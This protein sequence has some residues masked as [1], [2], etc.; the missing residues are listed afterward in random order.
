MGCSPSL[1]QALLIE[2]AFHLG[3][4]QPIGNA[5]CGQYIQGYFLL[6]LVLHDSVNIFLSLFP[7]PSPSFCKRDWFVGAFCI[8]HRA[9]Q[10]NMALMA[11]LEARSDEM[12]KLHA[13]K[14][15]QWTTELFYSR[16]PNYNFTW[17]NACSLI[18]IH[19]I[20]ARKR[21]AVGFVGPSGATSIWSPEN[22]ILR[23]RSTL[24]WFLDPW[25]EI[26]V[27]NLP[28]I[29]YFAPVVTLSGFYWAIFSLHFF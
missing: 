27:S 2:V 1:L 22:S 29:M 14:M 3:S 21:W 23:W 17:W 18:N 11:N 7:L 9:C 10:E 19:S 16:F 6:L 13:E 8:N 4:M 20:D 15:G 25:C 24:Q 26:S 5:K 12:R 28:L